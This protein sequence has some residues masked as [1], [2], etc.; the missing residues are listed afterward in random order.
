MTETPEQRRRRLRWLTLGEIIAVV[1]V[2]I[3]ALG[4]WKSWNSGNQ[5]T[6]VVEQRQPIALTLRGKAEDDGRKLEITPV[7]QSH[8]LQSLAIGLPGR[9]SPINVGSDGQLSASDLESA[10]SKKAEDG[11]G[12]HRLRVRIQADYVEAGAARHAS[13]D[14]VLTYRWE[15]GGL[16]GGRSLRFVSLA[17]A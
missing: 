15:G 11:K 1:A 5:P 9:A 7:E 8:A 16:F 10:V 12:T 3:S 4:L 14:Y 2:A 13:H 6:A 17:R